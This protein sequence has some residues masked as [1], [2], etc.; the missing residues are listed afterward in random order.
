[1]LLLM[2]NPW[3]LWLLSKS[4]R[5]SL[6]RPRPQVV[7]SHNVSPSAFLP[8]PGVGL[9]WVSSPPGAGASTP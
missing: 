5:E 9:H 3:I 8:V 4:C 7:D 2:L 1:M 6:R